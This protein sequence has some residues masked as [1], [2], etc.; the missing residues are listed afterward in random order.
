LDEILAAPTARSKL[1]LKMPRDDGAPNQLGGVAKNEATLIDRII[2]EQS[3][4]ASH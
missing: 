4:L 2:A 1:D 3:A